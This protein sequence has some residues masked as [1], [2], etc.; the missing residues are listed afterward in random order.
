MPAL[1]I[2]PS[3]IYLCFT[4]VQI[5]RQRNGY[6]VAQ[7][8]LATEQ[9]RGWHAEADF[10]ATDGAWCSQRIAQLEQRLRAR[11]RRRQLRPRGPAQ[12]SLPTASTADADYSSS[13]EGSSAAARPPPPAAACD[14]EGAAVG[15]GSESAP[16]PAHSGCQ[17][18][19][20]LRPGPGPAQLTRQAL[21]GRRRS[22]P[23][24]RP[25]AGRQRPASGLGVWGAGCRVQG[26][27][28]RV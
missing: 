28:P 25:D 16:S 14:D 15:A 20:P 1:P 7:L 2:I 23:A 5:E 10:Q 17:V 19:S 22:A 21:A 8:Q 12:I 4:T 27:G 11:L 26:S 6:L 24:R 9:M 13:P 3:H 18:A